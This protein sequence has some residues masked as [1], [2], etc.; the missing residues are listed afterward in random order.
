MSSSIGKDQTLNDLTSKK[1]SWVKIARR[2]LLELARVTLLL[3]LIAVAASVMAMW[4]AE[5]S[6]WGF[7]SELHLDRDG[8]PV[9]S[10]LG[11]TLANSLPILAI[12]A[13]LIGM[14]AIACGYVFELPYFGWIKVI[15]LA[16]SAMPSF[17]FPFLPSLV[18]P[19]EP[20]SGL[21]DGGLWVPAICLALGDCNLSTVASQFRESLRF[22]RSQPHLQT[23]DALGQ[24][25]WA[26][27]WPRSLVSLLSALA[28]R[29]PH[30]IGGLVA[31]E[32][33][34]NIRGLG[35]ESY[36]AV[37]STPADLH[38][39]FWVCVI[40]VVLRS[41][42]RWAE[43]LARSIWLPETLHSND[44]MVDEMDELTVEPGDEISRV[45]ESSESLPRESETGA[46]HGQDDRM[47]QNAAESMRRPG[48]AAS[49]RRNLL[50]YIRSRPSHL[51]TVVLAGLIVMLFIVMLILCWGYGDVPD[52]MA[53][54]DPNDEHWYGTD[55]AGLDLVT[56]ARRGI[57]Q[58]ILPLMVATLMSFLAVPAALLALY[59]WSRRR[60][61]RGVLRVADAMCEF[62]AEWV[63]S[64]PKLLVLLAAFSV[65][66]GREVDVEFLGWSGTISTMVIR[67]FAV[68]GLLH[69][70]QVYRAVRDELTQLNQPQFLESILMTRSTMRQLIVGTILKNHCLHVLLIQTAVICAGVLHYDAVLG[71]L[72]IRGRG[73][74]FTWGSNLGMGVDAYLQ[75]APLDWFNVWVLAIPLLFVWVGIAA[76]WVLAESLKTLLGGY[77]YRLQ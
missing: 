60:K 77:V 24:S 26:H 28:G 8:I 44:P 48:L 1:L 62:V 68:I 46:V 29:V 34:F 54:Q 11:F 57:G 76:F 4:V 63:E 51:A 71:L 40:C 37:E 25:V 22:Q 47:T 14:G 42:F 43:F 75:Y 6:F 45:F 16:V 5:S 13:V 30:L 12:A 69:A 19:E 72:G 15:V 73:V 31:M 33:L 55:L 65:M 17:L 38:W 20:F 32:L 3:V 49:I 10:K 41:V 21:S 35:I 39:L 59:R 53:F 58:M 66:S 27:I 9:W 56:S 70:P 7:F 50:F 74:I 23:I 2:I 36:R 64:L 67:L 52:S 18:N 61:L